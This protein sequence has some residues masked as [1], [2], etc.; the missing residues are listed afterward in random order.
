MNAFQSIFNSIPSLTFNSPFARHIH[1]CEM[2]TVVV[3]WERTC[4]WLRI[5][6]E[7]QSQTDCFGSAACQAWWCTVE[8]TAPSGN[9]R[10]HTT[11]GAKQTNYSPSWNS[12][13]SDT[14]VLYPK[15]II[16]KGLTHLKLCSGPFFY[17]KY[18]KIKIV[19]WISLNKHTPPPFCNSRQR[20]HSCLAGQ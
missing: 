10:E 15:V 3:G 7:C 20:R 2:N 13:F 9:Q 12:C 14:T 19:V 1:W 17:C 5:L 18:P 11:A 6:T 8:Y 4:K 16:F